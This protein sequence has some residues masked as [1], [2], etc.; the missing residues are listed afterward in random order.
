MAPVPGGVWVAGD[1]VLTRLSLG[2]TGLSVTRSVLPTSRASGTS[3]TTTTALAVETAAAEIV[4][5]ATVNGLFR[6]SVA[7]GTTLAL[8]RGRAPD[9]PEG[10]VAAPRPI[11]PLSVGDDG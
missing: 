4:W 8:G 10:T 6:H 5:Y 11:E 2:P 1:G 7:K 3:G 9:P